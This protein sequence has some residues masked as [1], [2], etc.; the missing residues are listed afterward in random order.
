MLILSVV[1]GWVSCQVDYQ[2]AFVQATVEPGTLYCEMPR[3]FEQ[4]GMVLELK[5]NLYGQRDAPKNFF[6]HLKDN[7]IGRGYTPC[8]H[9]QC[10][11]ISPKVMVLIYVDDCIFFAK[12]QQDIDDA[13]ESLV[14]LRI[15]N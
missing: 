11:F 4:P 9:E 7:L 3:M 5:R 2:L 1:L 13:I 14:N 10:L 6:N 15:N 12:H 8:K